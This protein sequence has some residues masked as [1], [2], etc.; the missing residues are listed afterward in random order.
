[1]VWLLQSSTQPVKNTKDRLFTQN[2]WWWCYA[3][4]NYSGSDYLIWIWLNAHKEILLDNDTLLITVFENLPVTV[5]DRKHSC[6]LHAKSCRT[7]TDDRRLFHPLLYASCNF[8]IF[9]INFLIDVFSAKHPIQ[10]AVVRLR[11]KEFFNNI[12]PLFSDRQ[13]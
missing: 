10:W 7:V 12:M 8:H 13:L 5:T 4:I 9:Y 2:E 11:L 3:A 6:R 1:M